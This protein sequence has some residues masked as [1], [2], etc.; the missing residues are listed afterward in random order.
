MVTSVDSTMTLFLKPTFH[1]FVIL[2][3]TWLNALNFS[4]LDHD[5]KEMLLNQ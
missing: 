4:N 5:K 1:L 3:E 2:K